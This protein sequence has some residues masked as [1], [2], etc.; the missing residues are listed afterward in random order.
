MGCQTDKLRADKENILSS[1]ESET[2]QRMRAYFRVGDRASV[3]CKGQAEGNAVPPDSSRS[4]VLEEEVTICK[5][6]PM[7]SETEPHMCI[8]ALVGQHAL[9]LMEGPAKGNATPSEWS[10][11]MELKYSRTPLVKKG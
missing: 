9:A 11:H 10:I 1:L 3:H 5:L 4:Q 7:G 8:Y 6:S 2:E